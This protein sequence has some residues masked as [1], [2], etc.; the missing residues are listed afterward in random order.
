MTTN[1]TEELQD[2]LELHS[3]H[4]DKASCRHLLIISQKGELKGR[5]DREQ[6]ILKLVDEFYEEL[7]NREIHT[8]I[9]LGDFVSLKDKIKDEA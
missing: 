2:S 5:T 7:V 3:N 1:R 6:E 8:G 9:D 4:C